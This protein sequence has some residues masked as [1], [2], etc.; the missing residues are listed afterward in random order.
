VGVRKKAQQWTKGSKT[1]VEKIGRNCKK[2]NP[3]NTETDR[4]VIH[5]NT[6]TKYRD[7]GGREEEKGHG[8][9]GLGTSS[10]LLEPGAKGTWGGGMAAIPPPCSYGFLRRWGGGMVAG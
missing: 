4:K 7:G 6:K 5:Q 1:G 2:K 10:K 8:A 3:K 9:S